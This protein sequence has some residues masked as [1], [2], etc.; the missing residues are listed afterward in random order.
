MEATES[1]TMKNIILSTLFVSLTCILS[2]KDEKPNV[3]FIAIDD[4][5]DW[6]GYLHHNPQAIT[7]NIDKLAARGV[8]FTHS[9]CAAPV[10][11]P[12]RTALMSGMRPSTT[13][14]YENDDDWRTVIKPELTL[15]VHFKNSG[16]TT[17]GSG[18]SSSPRST[19][20][21]KTSTTGRS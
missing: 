3:L 12:S 18:Q 19:A 6:V 13:G 5:R 20:P 11:N 4:L 10:C 1:T 9:Y 8:A 2:A 21:I 7:P 16:Y 14:V 15:N 17:L